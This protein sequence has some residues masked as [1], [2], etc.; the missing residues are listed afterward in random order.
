MSESGSD[1]EKL[2]ES[3]CFPL[4]TQQRISP[5]Y[6]GMSVS[7]R[8]CCKS[9]KSDNPKNLAKVDL[10][11]SLRLHRS[12]AP[13][14]RPVVDFGSNDMVPHIA[15]RKTHQR[16]LKFSFDTPKRLLQQNRP[17]ADVRRADSEARFWGRADVGPTRTSQRNSACQ[18]L[19][20]PSKE[21]SR[22]LA[23]TFCYR[24]KVNPMHFRRGELLSA[25]DQGSRS[26]C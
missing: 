11:V 5:R 6:F 13:L 21:R 23:R 24:L 26:P 22:V 10:W 20:R 15:A 17:R 7:C 19:A 8:Y 16:L 2:N 9:R 12:L 4:L 18:N 14:R 25:G 1:P 3:K